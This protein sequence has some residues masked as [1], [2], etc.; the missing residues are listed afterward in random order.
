MRHVDDF[1]NFKR[2]LQEH[3]EKMTADVSKMFEVNLDKDELWNIYLDSFP[4]GFNKMFRKRREY[5]CSECRQF[6]RNIGNAVVIKDN[7]VHTIWEFDTDDSVFQPV[8]DA[9]DRYV[10]SY[11]VT[12]IYVSETK[13]IGVDVN[14]ELSS[15]GKTYEWQ[16]LYLEI[17]D[18][19][20]RSCSRSIGDIK[21]D[22]RDTRNVFKRSLD[23]ITEESVQIV[24]DLIAQNSLY[25]GNEWKN[26]LDAF[27]KYK[28]EYMEVPE[29]D[30]DNYAWE[31]SLQAG[32]VV[33][34]IRNH[35][36]GTLLV[37]ISDGMNLDDAVK[38]Y[39]LIV[40]PTNYKRSKPIFTKRMLEE[41][42]S[43][44]CELGFMDSLKR[45][46]A[47][48][49]DI[50]INNILF[51]NR[52][53]ARKI[54]GDVFEELESSVAINPKKFSKVEEVSVEKF[55]SDIL[56]TAKEL[57]LFL[58][59][60][61]VRNMVSLIAPENMDA[62]TMFKW[63]NAF[64]WA[65]TG[66]IT[67][68]DVKEN[69][70]RAGGS[71]DGVLRFSIQWNDREE[72]DANDLDAHCQE[73][74]RNGMHIFFGSDA[75]KPGKSKMGGQLDV[76][77]INPSR[78]VPAVENI[79]WSD[80]NKMLPGTYKFWVNCYSKMRG[81]SGFRAEI[82]VEGTIHYFDYNKSLRQ[83]ENVEVAEVTLHEDGSFT[84]K[85]LLP[86]NVSS[87]EVWGVQTNQFIPVSVVMY[88]PSYWDEQK[89]VG[90]RH[91]FFM[92]KD[93][94]NPESPNSFYNEYLK[95][96]LMKHRKVFEA[97]G[98]KLAV[99][100]ADDQLSGVGFSVTKRADVIVKVKG[101]T[102]RTIK[103]KF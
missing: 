30:R 19:F 36:M 74:G 3:F 18:R 42:K 84:V 67:D 75:R 5:D 56:P 63:N 68:S 64:S 22:Y 40:A 98:E 88:S 72:E 70:K 13:K 91:V 59:N 101:A 92:L 7:K 62:P 82:E 8:V 12:N 37:H 90:N 87:R 34:K 94:V 96:D 77:I 78:D 11:P 14:Y 46:F 99:T 43:K 20:V 25:R 15:D 57:E 73:P 79:T 23:E 102:E 35:S 51:S 61:H 52:D 28:Q 2:R 9:L 93:C 29:S 32:P 85:E 103:V 86:G 6:I 50:T 100:D 69:V 4:S 10:K 16:H 41:A 97:L 38:Q 48:L 76:D 80:K 81:T 95:E 31:K 39:E 55:I 66:N 53:A 89:G 71:V 1:M 54:A 83:K 33:G 60:K 21:G 45:R 44:I 26:A 65:Y 58:E 24:L 17:P 47:K 27:L 49:D